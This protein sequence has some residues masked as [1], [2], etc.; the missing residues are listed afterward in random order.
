MAKFYLYLVALFNPVWRKLGVDPLQLQVIL[1]TKLMMD[2][3]RPMNLNHKKQKESKNA[4]YVL[5]FISGL[6]GLFY[7]MAFSISDDPLLNLTVY[8]F[9]FMVM[10]AITLI[11]DFTHVLIDVKDNYIIL[12]KPVNDRTVLFSRLLHIGIHMSKIILPSSLPA[13]FYIIFGYHSVVGALLFLALVFFAALFVVFTVNAV[14]VIALKVTTPTKFKEIIN[15][16]QIAF[17][18][19]VFGIYNILPRMISKL[20]AVNINLLDYPFFYFAPPTWFAGT[21]KWLITGDA[22]G[23][24]MLFTVLTVVVPLVCIWLVIKVFAPS[25]NAKLASISG[26]SSEPVKVT[27]EQVT[28]TP[29]YKR[30][31]NLFTGNNAER[32]GFEISWLLTGRTREFKLKVYPSL[33]YIVIYFFVIVFSSMNGKKLS[34]NE[35]MDKL[36][37]SHAYI[38]LIY[39]STLGF[40]SAISNIAYTDKYK[41]AWI[42]FATPI[43]TPGDILMGSFKAALLK[44]FVPIYICITAVTIGVWGYQAIPNLLLGFV[45]VA[46]TNLF[47][48]KFYLRRFPFSVK[49]ET[50]KS[51]GGFMRGLMILIIPGALGGLHYL[52]S[53]LSVYL[54]WGLLLLSLGGFYLLYMNF[55]ETSWKQLAKY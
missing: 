49:V 51:G 3:R 10:L 2:D 31:A 22:K 30:L 42:Y 33:A 25:F 15:Y 34:F 26:S 48:A 24:F 12:P 50:D 41:S 35:F 43:Q 5:I 4:T 9:M 44:F 14:Y 17:T 37:Q 45:N 6:M 20:G 32:M 7:L 21:Y 13:F 36:T 38:I 16:I 8:F 28:R 47:L 52:A 19:L 53:I 40:I 46:L 23:I 27:Q 1:Q 29:L 55:K 11:S 54:I 18:I 39:A